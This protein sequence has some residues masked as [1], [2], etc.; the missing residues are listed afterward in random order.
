MSA[1]YRAVVT[2]CDPG[3]LWCWKVREDGPTVV[4]SGS[5]CPDEAT[6]ARC[7]RAIVAVLEGREVHT[8]HDALRRLVE[9]GTDVHPDEL[10]GL[11]DRVRTHQREGLDQ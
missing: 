5:E 8:L 4:A 11:L 1:R 3:T 10:S 7:A 6:A 9:R 2:G